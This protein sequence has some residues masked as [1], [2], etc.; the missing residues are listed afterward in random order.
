M[1]ETSNEF[2]ISSYR[3]KAFISYN[4]QDK[5]FARWLHKSLESYKIPKNLTRAEG[6]GPLPERLFPVFRDREDMS[7]GA[8]LSSEIKEILADS[9]Y[10]I[11]VCS[12]DSAKSRWVNEEIKHFR[13][14]G[15]G[16]RILTIIAGGVPGASA[17]R[18]QEDQECF[19]PA[20]RLERDEAGLD[21]GPALEPIAADA[22]ADADG[23][24][25]AK[26]KI[27]SALLDTQFN[28][29]RRREVEAQRRRM[30]GQALIGAGVLVT[31]A[32]I[33]I[34]LLLFQTWYARAD[35]FSAQA[36]GA[37]AQRDYA[38]AEIAAA[39]SL[40]Y[41]DVPATRELLFQAQL[42][43][44]RFVA[45][46]AELAK[47]EAT[48]ISRDGQLV[49]TVEPTTVGAPPRVLVTSMRDN[50]VRWTIALPAGAE[51]PNSI[52][53]DTVRNGAR[54]V[55][56][57]WP[58]QK[59]TIFR[60]GVWALHDGA[61]P[62]EFRELTTGQGL[63]GR[64]TK[65]IPSMAFNPAHNWIATGAEDGKLALWD[66]DAAQPRLIWEQDKTHSPDVHGI[67]FSPDGTLLG[68]AGGDYAGRIWSV[69]D[70]VGPNYTPSTPYHA[71][72][73]KEIAVLSGHADS[74]FAIAF[75]PDRKHVATGGY[76]R[77]IFIWEFD[78][79]RV[80]VAARKDPR[81]TATLT[82]NE[83]TIFA[84]TYSDDGKLLMSGASDGGAD[85]WDVE[86]SRLLNR[87]TPGQDII[88]AVAAPS[89]ESGVYIAGQQ[90]WSVFSVSG[91]PVL[92][93]LWNGGATVNVATYDPTGD[94]L[95]VSG[96]GDD[97]RIRVWDR[98][99]HLLHILDPKLPGEA[100]NGMAFSPD[101]RWLAAGGATAIHV[102]N[103]GTPGWNAVPVPKDFAHDDLVWGLCFDAK[104]KVL[105][106]SSQGDTA[107]I[108]RW[109]A[110]SWTLDQETPQLANS[111]YALACDDA[112][113]LLA[114][115]DSRARVTLLGMSDLH[116]IERITNV[117]EGELNVWSLSLADDTH[118]IVSGN[119]DGHVYSWIPRDPRWMGS[120]KATRRGTS[121]EDATVNPTINS[122][123]YNASHHW[124][125]AGGVG[126][127][128]EIYDANTMA[129]LH[130]LR[131]HDG[132][133]WWV[134]FD[135]AGTRLA[136]GGL[137]K[138]VRVVDLD[139]MNK[140]FSDSP[141]ALRKAAAANSGLT[142]R[143]S[144]ISPY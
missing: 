91:S 5:D 62:G 90:G 65:R 112:S 77:A 27:I 73:I 32:A 109:N 51:M 15:R 84:L 99:Y 136:Y 4:H 86:A 122:V 24:T 22:R 126:P 69:A 60:V 115:G 95:A 29:L 45:R 142:I 89:F 8:D 108:K 78:G 7:A 42:G 96:G 67:S 33:T 74:V 21:L 132:T 103:R 88:R 40:Y 44:V 39:E 26:L 125:A 141:G 76:D 58:E 48:A 139:A 100:V 53:F 106:T 123:A 83:G 50:K 54:Q 98:S 36:Q 38:K 94:Y 85:L 13:R 25:N 49:A 110:G 93:R 14:L 41:H 47:A 12:P 18:G 59:G 104:S 119:S 63:V 140:I 127:S 56:I 3:F 128:V 68:S 116:P 87:F 31:I 46:S 9:A 75:S 64:H 138:L 43:G 137:D 10:L 107:R 2:D 23:R 131:G 34:T 70:M 35:L 130:S 101:G 102:W 92:K 71:H 28:A 105:F 97:G 120:N 121:D 114:A 72:K 66:L 113:G 111:V 30:M 79:L 1:S 133:I 19:P 143:G 16:N 57:A 11:V 118:A 129:H 55:A 52:T 135:R 144:Q 134:T 81:R 117:H 82:G 20:L 124:I 37:L 61:A 6:S 17:I 80:P